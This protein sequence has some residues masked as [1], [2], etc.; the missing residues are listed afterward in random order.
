VKD[1]RTDFRVHDYG[2]G[3]RG[4]GKGREG[5]VF[6]THDI[7]VKSGGFEVKVDGGTGF[8]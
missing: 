1:E 6:R 8:G 7:Q 5:N 3:D 2:F 4:S